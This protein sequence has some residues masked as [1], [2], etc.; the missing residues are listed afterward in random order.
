MSDKLDWDVAII[1]RVVAAGCRCLSRQRRKRRKGRNPH[2]RGRV[3]RGRSRGERPRGRR[4]AEQRDEFAP[5]QLFDISTRP[6]R[7][8]WQAAFSR[9]KLHGSA[10]RLGSE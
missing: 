4:A 5:F 10:A 6:A 9:I 3:R 2:P 7:R 1:T 8:A